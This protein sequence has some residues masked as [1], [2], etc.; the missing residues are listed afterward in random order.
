MVYTYTNKGTKYR[1]KYY[2]CGKAIKK[3]YHACK[4]PSVKAYSIESAVIDCVRKIV[5]HFPFHKEVIASL[6]DSLQKEMALLTQEQAELETKSGALHE[7]I[8]KCRKLENPG[9]KAL[10]T[11][12]DDLLKYEQILSKLALKKSKIEENLI[13]KNEVDKVLTITTPS[14]ETFFPPLKKQII[15]LI[16]KEVTYDS[17]ESVIAITLKDTYVKLLNKDFAQ[18]KDINNMQFE[19]KVNLVHARDRYNPENKRKEP[20]LMYLRKQLVLAHQ[21]DRF[22]RNHKVKTLAEVSMFL[23][24]SQARISQVMSMLQLCPAIQE[25]ILFE[26]TKFIHSLS[27]KA[28]RRIPAET[29]WKKQQQLWDEL[30]SYSAKCSSI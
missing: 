25:E 17:Q 12:E 26:D 8:E 21:I 2:V 1:Y 7:H 6:N 30:K 13:L 5:G 22:I 20:E 15:D 18:D 16:L 11:L 24:I 9:S 29:N 3:G 27:E 23:H 28:I 10:K 14:W 19:F 4:S